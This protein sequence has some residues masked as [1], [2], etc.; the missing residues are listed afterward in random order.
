MKDFLKVYD[1]TIK[2][3]GPVFIGNGQE[4]NKKE[5]IFLPR[6]HKVLIPK[7]SSMYDYLKKKRLDHE[8]ERYMMKEN[9]MN[10]SEWIK[11]QGISEKDIMEWTEYSMDCG[12]AIWERGRQMEMRAFIKDVYGCP[13]IPGSSVK[14]MLRTILLA[15]DIQMNPNRYNVVKSDV[16]NNIRQRAN[17][18]IYLKRE[19]KKIEEIAFNKGKRTDRAADMVNDIMAGIIVSDSKPLSVNDLTL[20]Q[21]VEYHVDGTEKRLNLLRE[22]LKPGTEVHFNISIDESVCRISIQDIEN[23]IRAFNKQYYKMFSGKFP[24]VY[25]PEDNTVWLGGGTGYVSKTIIYNM[26]GKQ[27]LK[28]IPQIYQN[29]NVPREHGHMKDEGLG[30]SPHILKKTKYNGKDYQFGECV[31]FFSEKG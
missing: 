25:E 21:K 17:R 9:R 10:L 4:I 8:Y 7:L 3:C 6:Q 31:I 11:Q 5:Y 28:I 26:F 1:V 16:L 15:Y 12:D 20:C 14:G 13:Y 22:C 24:N 30:V 29:T 23:A 19:T 27:G 18:N 2:V